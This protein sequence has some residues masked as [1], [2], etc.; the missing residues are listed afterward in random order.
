[1]DLKTGRE[2]TR[3]RVTPVPLTDTVKNMVETM[4][5]KEGI[6]S[7]KFTNK[8]GVTLT[9]HDLEPGVDFDTINDHEEIE[10]CEEQEEHEEFEEIFENDE[11]PVQSARGSLVGDVETVDEATEDGQDL[12]LVIDDLIEELED[13]ILPAG[14]DMLDDIAE[15]SDEENEDPVDRLLRPTRERHAPERLTYSQVTAGEATRGSVISDHDDHND[16]KVFMEQKHNLFQQA[17][18]RDNKIE[19]RDDEAPV[20]ARFLD[21]IHQKYGFGQQY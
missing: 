9:H 14:E 5:I 17:V 6:T 13:D 11:T 1:M 8:R 2:I 15:E 4:A 3:G 10:E 19:Y 16:N 18:G 20:V 21:D 7:I 12:E